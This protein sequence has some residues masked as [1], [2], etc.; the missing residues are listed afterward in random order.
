MNSLFRFIPLLFNNKAVRGK[1]RWL[2]V[3][4][5]MFT[6]YQAFSPNGL[7]AEWG[8]PSFDTFYQEP[9]DILITRVEA[10]S[11]AQ[12]ETAKEFRSALEEF[13]SVAGFEGGDL[14]QRYNT[15]NAA[16]ADSKAAAESVNSRVDRVV[17][18]SNRLLEEWRDEL[19]Q[20]HD[21]SIKRRAQTQFDATRTQADKLIAAMRKA[22]GKTV[23]VLGAFRDQVLYLKH[24]LNTQAISSLKQSSAEIEQDVSAL[25]QDMEISIAEAE[26]FI[27]ELAL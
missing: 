17:D 20:Y 27:K 10:A 19:E 22:E 2:G 3:V 14:E 8:I 13:K 16:Y 12:Q 7:G 1:K 15:L 24:N 4:A 21:A 5:I 25:I 11:D 9:R 23:P 6:A 26:A 18:A